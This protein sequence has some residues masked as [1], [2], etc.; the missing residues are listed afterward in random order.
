MVTVYNLDSSV[1]ADH[2]V[3]LHSSG[4]V[5][6]SHVDGVAE[7]Y[8][9]PGTYANSNIIDKD[10]PAGE[11]VDFDPSTL[12]YNVELKAGAQAI[13]AGAATGAPTVDILGVTRAAPHDAGAYSYPE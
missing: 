11:F 4:P 12:T 13:G 5:F 6:C 2:N 8:G 10:A 3:A 1:E 9:A 7:F